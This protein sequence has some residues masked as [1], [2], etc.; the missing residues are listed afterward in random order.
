M[1][2]PGGYFLGPSGTGSPRALYGAPPRPTAILL[3]NVGRTGQ[4]VAVTAADR[5]QAIEDLRF[6]RAAVVII[7]N[8]THADALRATVQ[9]LLGEPQLV[10]GVWLWN[11]SL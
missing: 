7:G 8:V 2:I 1:P 6:W 4:V 10:D 9:Q 11:V 5:R 3:D